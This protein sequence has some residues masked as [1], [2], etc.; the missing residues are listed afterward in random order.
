MGKP[1]LVRPIQIKNIKDMIDKSTEACVF[2]CPMYKKA[3]SYKTER[4]GLKSYLLSDLVKLTLGEKV[5]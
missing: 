2:V 1:D 5:N 4:N 3:M